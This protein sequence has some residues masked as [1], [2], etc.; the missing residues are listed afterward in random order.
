MVDCMFLGPSILTFCFMLTYAVYTMY[1]RLW[2]QGCNALPFHW[3]WVS[4]YQ[5]FKIELFG[6]G[7]AKPL[8][9]STL[10][11]QKWAIRYRDISPRWRVIPSHLV[12]KLSNLGLAIRQWGYGTQ[13]Q[14]Q[15]AA[16]YRANELMYASLLFHSIVTNR[17][18][19]HNATL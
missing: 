19:Q 9:H 1:L 13:K 3:T 12:A 16:L 4:L 15:N 14:A 6:F 2:K 8:G 17:L 18:L 7:S 11:Y 5:D 10:K